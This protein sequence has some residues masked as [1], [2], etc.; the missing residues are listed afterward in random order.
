MPSSPQ[1]VPLVRVYDYLQA[2]SGPSGGNAAPVKGVTVTLTPIANALSIAPV[3]QIPAQPEISSV[4]DGNGYWEIWVVPTDNMTPS[5]MQYQVNDGFRSYKINPTLAGI[6]A[7]GWASSAITTTQ[8]AVLQPA[9]VSV[10]SLA[11]ANLTLGQVVFPGA[12]GLLMGDGNFVWDNVNKSLGVGS[13]PALGTRHVIMVAGDH[14][15]NIPTLAIND[16]NAG[17]PKV[18]GLNVGQDINAMFQIRDIS[19]GVPRLVIDTTGNVGVGTGT[20]AL[21]NQLTV[22]VPGGQTTAPISVRAGGNNI[23][24][25]H[26][27]P[28]G[29]AGTL[30]SYAGA[31]NPFLAFSGEAG[32]TNNTFRTRGFFASIL[33]GDVAGGFVFGTT[34][35]ANADNQALTTLMALDHSGRLGIGGAP[36]AGRRLWIYEDHATTDAIEIVDSNAA[37]FDSWVLGLGSGGGGNSLTF[38]DVTT[39][40]QTMRLPTG[41]GLIIAAPSGANQMLTILGMTGGSGIQL[42]NS[43]QTVNWF[44]LYSGNDLQF[45]SAQAAAVLFSNG[46]KIGADFGSGVAGTLGLTNVS[47]IGNG[48]QTAVTAPLIGTGG[49][50]A[51]PTQ[52]SK[53]IKIYDGATVRWL[54]AMV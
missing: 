9:Q 39:A 16:L 1:N 43:A 42:Q 52:V 31:G 20:V 54:P 12:Q 8:P 4:T 5:G 45:S 14:A 38:Y 41:G 29:Y 26:P 10:A 46:V 15:L 7:P 17:A 35:N 49:G 48:A 44:V 51:T 34:A 25:G 53:F 18:F 36:G 3:V 24:F 2:P 30:G 19:A 23:E 32:T 6:P 50:P 33:Q 21:T 47:N 28:A 11:V 22:G 37:P 13:A 27:N 40:S